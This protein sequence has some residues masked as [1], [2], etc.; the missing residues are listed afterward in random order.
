MISTID[1][2]REIKYL[3]FGLYFNNAPKRLIKIPKNFCHW[4]RRAGTSAAIFI[5]ARVWKVFMQRCY[6]TEDRAVKLDDDMFALPFGFMGWEMANNLASITAH[7]SLSLQT[8]ISWLYILIFGFYHI[9]WLFCLLY[10]KVTIK[11]LTI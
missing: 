8:I 2:L 5:S 6:Y 4:H 3:W 9:W 10:S 11:S 1:K 7:N